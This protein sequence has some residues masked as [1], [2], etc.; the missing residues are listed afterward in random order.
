LPMDIGH[1]EARPLPSQVAVLTA[2]LIA[3]IWDAS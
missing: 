1:T 3:G 2:T